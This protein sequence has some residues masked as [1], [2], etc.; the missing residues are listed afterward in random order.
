MGKS[1]VGLFDII[2]CEYPLPDPEIQDVEF[3][4]KTFNGGCMDQYTITKKGKL[5]FHKTDWIDVPEEERPF[6]GRPEWDKHKISRACGSIKQI[7]IGDMIIKY[8]GIINMYT[9]TADEKWY[10]YNIEFTKGEVTNV[11]RINE[12]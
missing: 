4:T 3:Q 6:Y 11:E 8:H 7:H 9:H 1:R 2:K 10:E 5:I 12:G